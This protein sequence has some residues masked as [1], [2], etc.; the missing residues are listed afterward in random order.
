MTRRDW[1][2]SG[3]TAIAVAALTAT[4][5][6][7]PISWAVPA[8]PR[9]VPNLPPSQLSIPS[10]KAKIA[11]TATPAP[12]QPISVTLSVQSP[13]RMGAKKV[14]VTITV[15]ETRQDIMSRS[16]PVPEQISQV[17]TS[18]MVGWTGKSTKSIALPLVWAKTEKPV[19][20]SRSS[21]RVVVPIRPA[22]TY[23]LALTSPLGEKKTPAVRT[24]T[25]P[26]PPPRVV[27]R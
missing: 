23:Q 16:G 18:V 21:G 5:I 6:A 20:V 4:L 27:R 3:V 9:A 19:T 8:T 1:W 26:T 13:P 12:G 22:T 25:I 17:Q 11:A 2:I 7:P 14:P 10:L 24:I 15:Y